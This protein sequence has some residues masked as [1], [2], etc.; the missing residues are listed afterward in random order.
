MES[1]NVSMRIPRSAADHASPLPST[2]SS[3]GPIRVAVG[4]LRREGKFLVRRREE[5]TH[6]GGLW[7]FPGGKLYPGEKPEAGLRREVLEETGYMFEDAILLSVKEHRY[8]DR[9]VDLWFYLCLDPALSA[10]PV[11]GPPEQ[12]ITMPELLELEMPPANRE[13]VL[14]LAEN[15]ANAWTHTQPVTRSNR[16]GPTP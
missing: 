2:P 13:V 3:S 4:I 7:E 8:P 1:E 15:V 11:P 10:A 14:F 6:L 16:D 12:W 5:S 9:E